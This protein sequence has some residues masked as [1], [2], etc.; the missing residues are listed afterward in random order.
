MD[1]EPPK[2]QVAIRKRPLNRKELTSSDPD[3]VETL[4]QG[5]LIIREMKY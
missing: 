3:I 4:P 5:G 1:R 2:I